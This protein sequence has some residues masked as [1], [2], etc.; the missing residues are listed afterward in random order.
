MP[1]FARVA[2]KLGRPRGLRG[3]LVEPPCFDRQQVTAASRRRRPECSDDGKTDAARTQPVDD[4]GL[5]YLL[6]GVLAMVRC[7]PVGAQHAL[8]F[9]VPKHVCG[10][11]DQFCSLGDAHVDH[12]AFRST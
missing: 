1:A 3:E 8:V 11:A 2:Q 9:P 6:C 12:L 10:Y 7:R 5:R 4:A